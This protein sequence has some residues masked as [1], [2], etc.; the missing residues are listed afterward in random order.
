MIGDLVQLSPVILVAGTGLL[1]LIIDLFRGPEV[2]GASH[3]AWITAIGLWAAAF[4]CY[5]LWPGAGGGLVHPLMNGGMLV[6]GYTLFFWLFLLIA[7]SLAVL[8]SN[9][10]DQENN[11][12]HGEYISFFS[13]ALVGMMVMVAAADMLVLFIALETMSLAV[14][15]L[16][17]MKRDSSRASEGA[18]KYFINGAVASAILLYGIALLWG[19]TGTLN[20]VQLGAALTAESAGGILYAAAGLVL[21]G[22]GFKVAVVPFH[23][24]TPDAY[25]GAPTPVSGFMAS[26]VKAAAFAALLRVVF[27]AMLPNLFGQGTFTFVDMVIGIGIASMLVGNLMAMHQVDVKRMLAYSSISHAGFIML[28]FS[29]VPQLGSR[30]G[31]LRY[32]SGTVLFYLVG[33]GF[34]TLLAFGVL[35]RL[36]KDGE[37][38]T[39]LGR[40]QG[41]ATR[42]PGLAFLLALALF[43][44]AGFPPTVGFFGKFYLFRELM[45]LSRGGLTAVVII[46]VINALF[47]VYYYLRPVVA[48]YMQKS[49]EAKE[50]RE[51]TN[52]TATF[53]LIVA[54][55]LVLFLGLFP[56]K[57]ADISREAGRTLVYKHAP[58]LRDGKPGKLAPYAAARKDDSRP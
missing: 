11:L 19:E 28:A 36:G 12:D 8:V 3:L 38:E 54:A 30:L 25:Q 4:I 23:M 21:V 22:F 13:F 18:F 2:K 10:F 44:L 55:L 48:M 33:Y 58:M 34:A 41:L 35:A 14:Y 47:S 20:L 6:D 24:W 31:E 26:A 46:A 49:E 57:L 27:T 53:A 29:L 39:E 17:A 15:A 51:I 16:V 42:R 56:A 32:A 43:S 1:V 37:E 45:V 9:G 7:T 40:L 50:P 5:K 52:P